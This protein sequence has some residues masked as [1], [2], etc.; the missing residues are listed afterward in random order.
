MPFPS[1]EG[2]ERSS[3]SGDVILGG[4]IGLNK[5]L[6]YFREHAFIHQREEWDV[7]AVNIYSLLRNVYT[8]GIL[9]KD[10]LHRL[11]IETD[12]LAT[13][14]EAYAHQFHNNPVTM[15][16]YIP[17]YTKIPKEFLREHTGQQLEIDHL[18][19]QVCKHLPNKI[20]H[21]SNHNNLHQFVVPLNKQIC[22]HIELA[23]ILKDQHIFQHHLP[24]HILMLSHCVMDLHLSTHMSKSISLIESYTGLIKH[25]PEFG[26]K[27]VKDILIPFNNV[28]H[29]L[30]GDPIHLKPLISG[31]KKT[32]L[33]GL[34]STHRWYLKTKYEILQDVR[35]VD[36]SITESEITKL[37][38]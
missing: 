38:L 30:F 11:E 20:T 35:K 21:T 13:Y 17:D 6:M 8:P 4:S 23:A 15:I 2:F 36:P 12:L 3:V 25:L 18:Y 24:R 29:R 1:V 34:A 37:K 9:V 5:L 27:L 10:V 28:T 32:E 31:R 22:P 14:Y 16:F 26:S 7:F 19:K 33:L